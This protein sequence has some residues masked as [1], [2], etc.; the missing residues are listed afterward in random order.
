[1]NFLDRRDTRECM[2]VLS[3]FFRLLGGAVFR[4]AEFSTLDSNSYLASL[5]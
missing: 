3:P 1:M 4:A 5:C 2:S